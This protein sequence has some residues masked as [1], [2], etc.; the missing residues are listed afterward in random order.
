MYFLDTHI[1]AWLYQKSLDLLS[2]KAKEVIDA[3]DLYI[4][5][6]VSLELEYLYEIG[7]IKDD[8][9]T[10]I[11]YLNEKIGLKVHNANFNR[12]M[13]VAIDEKWTRDPFDRMIVSHCRYRDAFLITKDERVLKNY[14]K[15]IF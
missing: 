12:I 10:I 15:A 13:K 9:K 4:S 14:S 5:P 7:R 6:I 1:V 11:K 8:S 3:N 2:T